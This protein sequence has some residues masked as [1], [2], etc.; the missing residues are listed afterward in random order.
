MQGSDCHIR[1]LVNS[2]ICIVVISLA[3]LT[4]MSGCIGVSGGKAQG[5]RAVTSLMDSAEVVMNDAPQHALAL[6]DSIAPESIH[7][8]SLNARYALLYSESL[9]K[10][11]IKAP[12][13][14]IIMIAVRY[15]SVKND[16]KLKPYRVINMK[17]TLIVCSMLLLASCSPKVT[18]NIIH[19]HTPLESLDDV[20]LLKEK[21]P[22]PADAEWMGDIEV[23]GAG[24]YDKMAEMTRFKAWKSGAK[25][26]RVKSFGSNGVRSDIHEMISDVY[27][28]DTSKVRS[29]DI[30]VIN[31]QGYILGGNNNANSSVAV[32]TLQTSGL[33]NL[34]MDN[35]RV[36]VGYGRRLNKISPELNIYEREHIKRLLNGVMFGAEYIQ[37]F[38]LSKSNGLGLR[39]Q[40][41]HGASSDAATAIYED[42]SIVEGILD[43]KVNISYLGP[44][45]SNRWLSR[46]E[47][48]LLVD[49]VGMGLLLWKDTSTFN[50]E[51]ATLRGKT[52]GVAVDINYSYF[53]SDHFTVGA[54]VSFT[55]GVIRRVTASAGDETATYDLD[56]NSYEGLLHMGLCAQIIYTF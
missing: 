1:D 42:E 13:D 26:V 16:D 48:H 30:R 56:K 14:S 51:K 6:I 35:V 9:F 28:S 7:I 20:V 45:Y 50:K 4:G 8:R 44:V 55:S 25:Y 27:R 2:C 32:Q 46:N 52:L 47:K 37:Y 22:V 12:N 33:D 23:K 40:V 21:E 10:N 38:K 29:Q 19:K 3:M 18:T 11:Y 31:G 39:Y 53:V 15:Y 36:Y 43:E 49:N 24:N 17:G 54:D 41:M 34:G 5:R